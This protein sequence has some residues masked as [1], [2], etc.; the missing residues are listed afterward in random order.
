MTRRQLLV[1]LIQYNG[2]ELHVNQFLQAGMSK[3][4]YKTPRIGSI[5][6]KSSNPASGGTTDATFKTR[7]LSLESNNLQHHH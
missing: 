6:S 1:I 3:S 5:N 2:L 7:G 4:V